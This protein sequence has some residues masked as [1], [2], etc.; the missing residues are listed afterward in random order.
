MIT[1]ACKQHFTWWGVCG[2]KCLRTHL[3][4][5]LPVGASS[6]TVVKESRLGVWPD[7]H[8]P[9]ICWD[10]H[11]TVGDIRRR[12]DAQDTGERFRVLA[13]L[14]RELKPS[15]VWFFITPSVVYSQFDAVKP[16]LG[17]SRRFWEYLLETWHELGK[18]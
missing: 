17:E 3:W 16:W 6:T 8:I 11:W 15:E 14:M 2:R 18:L 7:E 12:L 13:W 9:Y 4:G 1:A 5:C 10:R